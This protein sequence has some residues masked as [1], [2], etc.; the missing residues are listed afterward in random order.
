ML[1]FAFIQRFFSS[2]KAGSVPEG[3]DWK[4]DLN[5]QSLT[6]HKNAKLEPSL[7]DAKPGERFQFERMGYFCVDS[8]DSTSEKPVFNRI[9]TLK[10]RMGKNSEKGKVARRKVSR[11]SG[12]Y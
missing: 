5:P 1:R 3:S 4:D 2:E 8:K 11:R 12:S 6:I 10:R 9:V 7:A